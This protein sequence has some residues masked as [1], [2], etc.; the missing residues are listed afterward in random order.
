MSGYYN[1]TVGESQ[2]RLDLNSLVQ[3]IPFFLHDSSRPAKSFQTDVDHM[4]LG[5]ILPA[6]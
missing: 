4:T 5:A 2:R 6:A 1:G 3:S